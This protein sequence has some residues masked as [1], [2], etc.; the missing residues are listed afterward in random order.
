MLTSIQLFGCQPNPLDHSSTTRRPLS[1]Y[2][3]VR[4]HPSATC[5]PTSSCLAVR[6]PPLTTRRAPS[7]RL[8]VRPPPSTT[9]RPPY[10][11]LVVRS[12]P[13]DHTP[14]SI[15][16]IGCKSDPLDQSSTNRRPP[17]SCFD[18]VHSRRPTSSCLAVH[19]RGSV[20]VHV[21]ACMCAKSRT[22]HY[23]RRHVLETQP[24]IAMSQQGRKKMHSFQQLRNASGHHTNA[25]RPS[26]SYSLS[27]MNLRLS[28]V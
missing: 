12:P 24:Y 2:F 1:S 14:T 5:S 26:Q 15:H 16:L 28:P 3:T 19:Q 4:S 7:S 21:C 9:C 11:C 25:R 13:V 23:Q 6:P 20:C 22:A 10:S 18:C 27:N 17:S 8:A